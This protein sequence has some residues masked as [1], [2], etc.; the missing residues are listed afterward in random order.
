MT[1]ANHGN[2]VPVLSALTPR[3]VDYRILMENNPVYPHRPSNVWSLA[4]KA[5]VCH[6]LFK[7]ECSMHLHDCMYRNLVQEL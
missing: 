2:F 1:E 6:Y 7:E 3:C 5:I 4:K